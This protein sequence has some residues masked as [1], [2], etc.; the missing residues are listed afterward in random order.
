M[1]CANK[2]AL[3]TN[4]TTVTASQF[5]MMVRNNN[6]RQSSVFGIQ[7]MRSFS[8][9]AKPDM[10]MMKEADE[11]DAYLVSDTPIILQAGASWCGPCNMLKPMLT[12]ASKSFGD[13]VDYVYM[14]I[15]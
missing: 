14:D 1:A 12:K 8:A 7:Q 11:W 13:K 10:I 6:Q 15:D 4:V 3:N 9:E 2:M 5:G